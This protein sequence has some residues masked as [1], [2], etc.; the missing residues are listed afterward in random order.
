MAYLPSS[1]WGNCTQCDNKDCACVKVG[2]NLVC[3]SCHRRNKGQEQ[4]T[5]AN[6]REKAR[7]QQTTTLSTN[8]NLKSSIRS[9]ADKGVV[10]DY[11]ELDRWFKEKRS[12][13]TGVCAN[14]GGKSCKDDD[15]YYKFS[16]AHILP[17]NL[18]KSVATH[19]D[20]WLELCF[21]GNSCHT[22]F[23]QHQIDIIDLHCFDSVIEK[24]VKI[25]PHIAK[26][27]QR[28]IPPILIEYLKNEI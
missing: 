4:I 26:E 10:K 17:K 12:Q 22:N 6:E 23:D 7:R 27:E 5:K 8:K 13:M 18:F 1:K 28:R 24:F 3:I 25:Y 19:S 9:L 20:N 11:N 15:K 14:C 2:K 21:F 16:I